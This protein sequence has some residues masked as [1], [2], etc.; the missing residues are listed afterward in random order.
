MKPVLKDKGSKKFYNKCGKKIFGYALDNLYFFEDD[1][2]EDLLDKALLKF[3]N[4][5]DWRKATRAY[6][7]SFQDIRNKICDVG[8]EIYAP[9]EDEDENEDFDDDDG[10]D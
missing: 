8:Y 1:K 5:P 7:W 9:C 2:I 6:L 3:Q 4:R 10:D